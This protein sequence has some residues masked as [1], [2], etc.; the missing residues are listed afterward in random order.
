M[1]RPRTLPPGIRPRGKGFVYDWRDATGKTFSRKAGDTVDEAIAYKAKID[2]ELATGTFVA[3]SKTTFAEY[4]AHWIETYPLKSQTRR[5][6]RSTLHA[7]LVPFFGQYRLVKITPALV[8]EWYAQQLTLGL[9]NNTVREHVAILKSILKTA[10]ADGHLPYLPTTGLRVPRQIKRRPKVL[11]F[12]Q[13]WALV[14]A[15]PE[16]WCALFAIAIFTGLR[17][18]EILALSRDDVDLHARVIHVGATLSEVARRKP[19]LM[20]EEPKSEAGV[21]DVP[22]VEP[23]AELLIAHLDRLPRDQRY[24]FTTPA[25]RFLDRTAVYKVWC[26]LRTS[27][28][29]PNLRFHDLRHTAASLLLTYSDAKLS[30]LKEILGHSQIAHT[31]DLYGHLVPGRLDAIRDR[32]GAALREALAAPALGGAA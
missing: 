24:L 28:G 20:I 12:K 21:R 31:V 4:A 17:L 32:F 14:M 10:Q 25:G 5:G 15:A 8:R 29:L 27:L 13:A 1:A 9:A 30:E 3:G 26:P 18:G 6:Y 2:A 16:E 7:H 19:R 23:L 22:I 11:T